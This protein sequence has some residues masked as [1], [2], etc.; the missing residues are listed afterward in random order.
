MAMT[1]RAAPC[2]KANGKIS[3]ATWRRDDGFKQQGVG[4]IAPQAVSGRS[5]EERR[6]GERATTSRKIGVMRAGASA[7]SSAMTTADMV[8]R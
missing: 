3:G 5:E 1:P 4:G 2:M 8:S 7:V 6:E